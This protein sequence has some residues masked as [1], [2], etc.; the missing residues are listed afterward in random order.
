MMTFWHLEPSS[1]MMRVRSSGPAALRRSASLLVLL[2]N[3]KPATKSWLCPNDMS[4]RHKEVEDF[5]FFVSSYISP[6]FFASLRKNK[7]ACFFSGY[8]D[9][10]LFLKTFAFCEYRLSIRQRLSFIVR[11][12]LPSSSFLLHLCQRETRPLYSVFVW[13][14]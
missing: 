12:C 10:P 1:E 14:V 2:K 9:T 4:K 13:L 8:T 5:L 6:T 11:I 7:I 3:K